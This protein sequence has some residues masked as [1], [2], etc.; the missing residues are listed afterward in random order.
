MDFE[1]KDGVFIKYHGIETD[2][3]IPEG[4]TEI[5]REA[6]Y[7]SEIKRVVIPD[8]VTRIGDQAF[9]CCEQLETIIIPES[10]KYIGCAAFTLS[11][12]AEK[13]LEQ[14]PLLIINHIL[15][16]SFWETEHYVIPDDVTDFS[17]SAIEWYPPLKSITC[18]GIQFGEE[19]YPYDWDTPSYSEYDMCRSINTDIIDNILGML[20]HKNLNPG[21]YQKNYYCSVLRKMLDAWPESEIYPAI[22]KYI[23]VVMVVLMNENQTALLQRI[24][25]SGQ[26]DMTDMID[27]YILHA[28]QRKKYEIQV[29]LMNYKHQHIGYQSQ[30]E[31]IRKKFEL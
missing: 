20:L 14:N 16:D 23:R 19:F 22:R 17:L 28:N 31:I 8:S 25:D 30:E 21:K 7:E 9:F 13:Q 5:R 2:I 18:R 11:L 27:E 15:V 24:L 12:W 26:L 3:I 10:V 29:L 4:V 1:I 6:F